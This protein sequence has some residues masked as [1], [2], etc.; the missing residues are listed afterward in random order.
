MILTVEDDIIP[1]DRADLSDELG[2]KGREI[3][4]G[5]VEKFG[6][7]PSLPVYNSRC[8]NGETTT[9]I[10]LLVDLLSTDTSAFGKKNVTSQLVEL[11]DL[12]EASVDAFPE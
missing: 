12:E 5:I 1:T 10:K 11:F 7:F 2:I 9:G 6:H 4:R 3:F 8:D